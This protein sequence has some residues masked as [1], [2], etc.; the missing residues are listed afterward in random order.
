MVQSGKVAKQE[1]GSAPRGPR[2]RDA[3][4]LQKRRVRRRQQQAWPRGE[5]CHPALV[6][7]CTRSIKAMSDCTFAFARVQWRW[8][9]DDSVAYDV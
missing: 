9:L 3:L 7:I 4:A 2:A 6:L 8:A 5:V 1:C